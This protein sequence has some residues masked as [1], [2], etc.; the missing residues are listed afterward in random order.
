MRW[1]RRRQER[2]AAT[3][4]ARL[5]VALDALSG[6]R[7]RPSPGRRRASLGHAR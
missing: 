2:K 6:S 1:Y 4:A 5:I 3:R 7:P